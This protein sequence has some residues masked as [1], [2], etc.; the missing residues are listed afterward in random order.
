MPVEVSRPRF[1]A[2][3]KRAARDLPEQFVHA[4]ENI[5]VEIRDR[6]TRKQL[7]SVGLGEDELLLGLYEGTPLTDRHADSPPALPDVIFLFQHDLEDACDSEAQLA[8]EVRI[9]LLHEI[10][11]YFGLDEDELAELGYG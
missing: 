5:R 4:L 8:E 3:V 6:P 11:H 7:R 1:D 9:T 10:G 2:L